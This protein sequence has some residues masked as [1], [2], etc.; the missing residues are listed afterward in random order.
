MEVKSFQRKHS[1]E[2]VWIDFVLQTYIPKIDLLQVFIRF[3][4]YIHKRTKRQTYTL[5]YTQNRNLLSDM[6]TKRKSRQPL[7]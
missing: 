5:M 4:N 1:R 2:E 3:I 7:S 6:H